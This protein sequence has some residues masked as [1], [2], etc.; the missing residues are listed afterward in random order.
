MKER[1]NVPF[2]Y[3]V[4]K[5]FGVKGGSF[6]NY[7][8]TGKVSQYIV[9]QLTELSG[10]S[11][12]YFTGKKQITEKKLEQFGDRIASCFDE[13]DDGTEKIIKDNIEA[14]QHEIIIRKAPMSKELLKDSIFELKVLLDYLEY[15]SKKL[16]DC[17]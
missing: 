9:D 3:A 10:I 15:S 13:A 17:Q 5:L 4:E 14:L 11:S 7:A 8:Y 2:D 12:D 6:R 1:L 16:N